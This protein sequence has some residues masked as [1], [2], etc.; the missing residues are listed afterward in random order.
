[1][2]FQYESGDSKSI[3]IVGHALCFRIAIAGFDWQLPI[4]TPSNLRGSITHK[5]IPLNWRVLEYTVQLSCTSHAA[6]IQDTGISHAILN[7]IKTYNHSDSIQFEYF[8]ARF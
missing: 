1:M 7:V 5:K 2:S 8:R 4:T 3:H 6:F